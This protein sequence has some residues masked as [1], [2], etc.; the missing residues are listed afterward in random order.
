[1]T[2][3][4]YGR[5]EVL[6]RAGVIDKSILWLCVCSCGNEILVRGES[7][8]RGSTSSCGCY[9]VELGIE[10]GKTLKSAPITHGHTSHGFV[11]SEY[12]SWTKMCSRCN[13]PSND[14]YSDYGGRGISVFTEWVGRGGFI[15]F[16]NHVGEK[17]EPKR[18]YSIDRIDNNENYEPGNV[19]WATPKQQSNNRRKRRTKPPSF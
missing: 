16:L 7:L 19:R 11:S 10:K 18:L 13:N 5:L 3:K 15:H 1:M 6:R 14:R 17:P 9:R 8:R 12:R 2:G 4:T